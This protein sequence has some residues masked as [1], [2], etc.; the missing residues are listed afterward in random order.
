MKNKDEIAL[1]D[2]FDDLLSPGERVEFEEILVEYIDLAID[3]RK[4]ETLRRILRNMPSTFKPN[5]IVM[6][7]ISRTILESEEMY[8]PSDSESEPKDKKSKKEKKEKKEKKKKKK[9]DLIEESAIDENPTEDTPFEYTPIEESFIEENFI[10]EDFIEEDFTEQSPT[11]EKP[12]KEKPKK[13]RPQ[14]KR[15]AKKRPFGRKRFGLSGKS[16]FRIKRLL[17]FLIIFGFVGAGFSVYYLYQKIDSTFPWKVNVISESSQ[18]NKNLLPNFISGG[19]QLVTYK[20]NFIRITVANKGFIEL[21]GESEIVSINGT[22]SLNSVLLENGNLKFSPQHDNNLFQLIYNDVKILSINS[23]FELKA[24]K[25]TS[26]T[27]NVLSNFVEIKFGDIASKIPHNHTLKIFDE[28]NISIPLITS[29]S[30]KFSRL[31]SQ[32]DFQQSDKTLRSILSL[33]K[34]ENAFTLL[35]MLQKVT[36]GN[37]ELIITKLQKFFPLPDSITKVDILLLDDEALNTWWQEIYNAI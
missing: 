10:E 5:E 27:L 33:S 23:E 13:E 32:F 36:P 17:Y 11:S 19:E 3:L 6:E 8:I 37:K 35:F 2:Y 7:N 1:H 18:S 26:A 29:S 12:N 22:Q 34:K 16:K 15:S 31:I 21:K 25:N 30:K 20:D 14:K 24:P 28:Y 4:L 9:K